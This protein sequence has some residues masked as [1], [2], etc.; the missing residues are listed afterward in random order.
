MKI[1][2]AI[3]AVLTMFSAT[4]K[5]EP[6][7]KPLAQ[8][9]PGGQY[10]SA[11]EYCKSFYIKKASGD[12][13]VVDSA[14]ANLKNNDTEKL[15]GCIGY[16]DDKTINAVVFLLDVRDKC[17]TE[18]KCEVNANNSAATGCHALFQKEV[19]TSSSPRSKGYYSCNSNFANKGIFGAFNF[20]VPI[21]QESFVAALNSNSVKAAAS[22]FARSQYQRVLGLATQFDAVSCG[23]CAE[24][25]KRIRFLFDYFYSYA[26]SAELETAALRY[27]EVTGERKLPDWMSVR[28]LPSA[29]DS[30]AAK[31]EQEW[32]RRYKEQ[33][34]VAFE[35]NSDKKLLQQFIIKRNPADPNNWGTMDFDGLVPKAQQM[36]I[37]RDARDEAAGKERER[38]RAENAE[39]ERKAEAVQQAKAAAEL[40]AAQ[41]AEAQRLVAWRRTLKIGDDTFCGPVI[42]IKSTMLKIA[43]RP[44]LQGFG[45][46]AWLK[47]SEVFP[48]AYGCYNRNGRLFPNS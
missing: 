36:Y 12:W 19:Y 28:L 10:F 42:E 8:G 20:D 18:W 48:E 11:A 25:R 1:V 16:L 47:A 2:F 26:S 15:Q 37:A 17:G 7:I 44:Q 33:V 40:A 13:T 39:K 45:N 32:R 23:T 3:L 22:D 6:S 29:I 9:T 38:L 43:V 5:A 24:Q 46:E 14:D 41:K 31:G 34:K 30:V 27:V 21:N 35:V 4:A